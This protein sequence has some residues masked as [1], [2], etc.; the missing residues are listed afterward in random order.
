M[1]VKLTYFN[2][3]GRA[4]AIRLLLAEL[5]I[6]YEDGR[7]RSRDELKPL[8]DAG[9]LPFGQVPLLEVDGFV[10]VQ[11]VSIC[12]YLA[13]TNG[14]YGKNP[15]S[16][17]IADMV[18]DGIQDVLQKHSAATYAGDDKKDELLSKF[19]K[20]VLPTWLTYLQNIAAKAGVETEGYI[21]GPDFS[22]ADIILFDLLDRPWLDV[23]GYTA[24]L[25]LKER[26]AARPNI[27]A[28]L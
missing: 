4:E 8:R 11:S 7:V 12:R 16:D 24:L 23:S 17:F 10:M 25:S 2:G 6:E 15:K 13:R 9:V 3:R 20:E 22:Y 19:R 14:L 1:G 5:N 28:Y 27:A 26:I 21:T 18:V